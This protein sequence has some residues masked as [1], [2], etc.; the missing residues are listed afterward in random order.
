MNFILTANLFAC[1]CA[2]VSFIYGL[3]IFFKPNK[4]LYAK[5]IVLGIGC[6]AFGRLFQVV[7]LLTGETIMDGFQLGFLGFIGSFMFFFCANYGLM[8]SLIDDG[9][10]EYKKYRIIPIAAP[11]VAVVLYII[12]FVFLKSDFLWMILGAVLTF[13]IIQS[14]YFNL[15]HL[16]FPDVDF[17]IAK[18]IKSYNLLVLIFSV[19]SIS[20][21]A[22]MSMRNDPAVLIISILSGIT[23]LLIVPMLSKGVKKWT[24]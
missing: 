22:A 20:E 15:K 12:L 21:C 16:I 6:S 17:G 7:R 3:V 2:F 19:L 1:I 5:M 14:S 8:D 11:L 18:C 13:F 10:A 23:L 24:I 4:A 9:C